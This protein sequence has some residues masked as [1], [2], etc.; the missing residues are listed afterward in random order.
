MT[1]PPDPSMLSLA[2]QAFVFLSLIHPEGEEGAARVLDEYDLFGGQDGQDGPA[3]WLFHLYLYDEMD[4]EGDC[5]FYT[6]FSDYI[7]EDESKDDS[8][9]I[10]REMQA[11]A[12]ARDCRIDWGCDVSDLRVRQGPGMDGLLAIAGRSL[13]TQGYSL[14]RD[15]SVSAMTKG[16]EGEVQYSGWASQSRDDDRLLALCTQWALPVER[17]G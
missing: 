17:L 1:Q 6:L 15:K 9:V 16:K 12:S 8:E 13:L 4:C 11:M 10:I 3:D 14:W 2:E 5:V 7:N